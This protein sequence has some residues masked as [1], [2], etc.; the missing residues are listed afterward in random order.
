[1]QRLLDSHGQRQ[2]QN[3]DGLLL[4]CL[5]NR[6]KT[7]TRHPKLL[8]VGN[9]FKLTAMGMK[10]ILG[11]MPK[12]KNSNQFILIMPDC[13][14]KLIK[15]VPTSRTSVTHIP[16]MFYDHYTVPYGILLYLLSDKGHISWVSS[17]KPCAI[18]LRWIAHNY[19]LPML[20]K[21]ASRTTK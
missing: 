12:P 7:Q 13:Y 17:S 8:L 4:M 10:D 19:R 9:P 5:Y 14:S 15:T 20:E 3:R 6:A 16:F 21:R 18:S 2:I 1:M 11:P